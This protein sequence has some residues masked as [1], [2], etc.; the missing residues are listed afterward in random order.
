MY[1][2]YPSE[3]RKFIIG[4][5]VNLNSPT[6]ILTHK[7]VSDFLT[8]SPLKIV[9]YL[10]I[11]KIKCN[12]SE[13]NCIVLDPEFFYPVSPLFNPKYSKIYEFLKRV[14]FKDVKV[15]SCSLTRNSLVKFLKEI[16]C[17]S[18][19]GEVKFDLNV[20]INVYFGDNKVDNLKERVTSNSLIVCKDFKDSVSVKEFLERNFK[21]VFLLDTNNFDVRKVLIN[22]FR[23][24]KGILI[25][26]KKLKKFV[27]DVNFYS[28]NYL[29][30]P[31]S[32]QEFLHDVV[33]FSSREYNFFVSLKDEMSVSKRIIKKPYLKEEYLSFLNF[34]GFRGNRLDYLISYL[35]SSVL[36]YDSLETDSFE[37]TSEEKVIF[38]FLH[39]RYFEYDECL[40]L[41]MGVGGKFFYG[42]YGILRG[43][44]KS[45]VCD[46]V[47][48]IVNK[49]KLGFRY[50]FVDGG[51]V[52]K[53]Y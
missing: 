6:L 28:V 16:G 52:K 19:N 15:F 45:Y 30:I 49:G 43:V 11:D 50:F 46:F 8:S 48:G 3:K 1:V 40:N 29:S 35:N 39:D 34:L 53:V 47:N 32:I 4:E 24:S 23:S 2:V 5:F 10:N 37:L 9:S 14:R 18:R 22:K 31:K 51:I 12:F 26:P 7:V 25:V 36:R 13:Y 17:K 44:P 41:L 20:G 21:N 38:N 42:G 33:F 27:R